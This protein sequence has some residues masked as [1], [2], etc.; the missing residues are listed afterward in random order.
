MGYGPPPLFRRG[1]SARARFLF[2]V[3]LSLVTI[4][5]DGRLRVLDGF[6]NAIITGTTPIKQLLF[7]PSDLLSHAEDYFKSKSTL[8]NENR[9]LT[10]SN[11]QLLL[12]SAR[13]DEL[14]QENE[15]L[16]KLVN[17]LPKTNNHSITTEVIGKV[18]DPFSNRLQVN[19]GEAEGIEVGMPV[20]GTN[21]VL[22][23]VTR[24][25]QHQS[26]V[27]LL[28]DHKQQIAVLDERTGQQFI[29]AGT[30]EKL[31]DILFVQP[32]TDIQ[33]GDRLVTSGLDQL[34]PRNILVGVI[35]NIDYQPGETY[36]RVT[37]APSLANDVQFATIILVNPDPTAALTE[38]EPKDPFARRQR[39]R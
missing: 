28:T 20:I 5:V 18:A 12:R 7:L 33:V 25:V 15:R 9:Q 13:L 24:T 27:T 34:F 14:N 31:L 38:Q 11:Q 21:G 36:K 23:Q 26:E 30:G 37:A 17:A 10:E 3:V 19:A 2:F 16:R 22:G 6:R 39:K 8:A 35:T 1:V 29:A 4:L 32:N